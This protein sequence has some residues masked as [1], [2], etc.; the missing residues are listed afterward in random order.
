MEILTALLT[1]EVLQVVGPI[2]GVGAAVF[3]IYFK[4][5]NKGASEATEKYRESKKEYESDIKKAEQNNMDLEKKRNEKLAQI[6]NIGGKLTDLI[7]LFNKTTRGG[8][9]ASRKTRKK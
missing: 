9:A 7:S 2:L 8:K 5:K 6:K 3:Y 1:K 4:G